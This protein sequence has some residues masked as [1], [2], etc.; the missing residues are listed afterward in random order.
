MI[1]IWILIFL[2]SLFFLV[3]SSDWFTES[4]EEIGFYLNLSPFIIGVTIVAIGTS[5]PELLSSLFA[6]FQKAPEIIIGNVIGSNITNIFLIIGIVAIFGKKIIIKHNLLN[7]D[8]PFLIGSAFFLYI[9]I[10]DKR[11][12]LFESILAILFLI[13][14]LI[15]TSK[16]EKLDI[17][18]APEIKHKNSKKKFIINVFI[19]VVSGILLFISAKYTVTSIIKVAE[20]LGIATGV[21]AMTI[22]ALGT[23]LPELMVSISAIKRNNAEMA[24]GN[25]LGSNIFNILGVMGITGLFG[26]ITIVTSVL[27][28]ALPMLLIASFL[29]FFMTQDK[30]LTR[31]EGVILL[32]FYIYFIVHSYLPSII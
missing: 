24:I 22:V 31:W 32:I 18:V 30:E 12:T 7:V 1:I 2:I 14:Y 16:T 6:M 23:S 3:K 29:F 5:L 28:F 4:A 19:L 8:L 25:V 11:F 10:I 17:D 13:T 26:T 21:L 9:T 20:L 27:T 15:Y